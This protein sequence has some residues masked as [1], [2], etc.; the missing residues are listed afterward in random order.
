MIIVL[1]GPSSAGKT[2]VASTLLALCKKPLLHL[3]AD[4]FW[5]TLSSVHVYDDSLRARIVIALHDAIATL[6]RNG[7][8]VIVDGSLP[9]D[10]ALHYRCL[11][12][13]RSVPGT[14]V[15]GVT[16]SPEMLAQREATRSDRNAGWAERQ[17]GIVFEGVEL[18]AIVDTSHR[19]PDECVEELL[20][21][22]QL[23]S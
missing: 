3:E 11:E 15:I 4:R 10:R 23:E 13:L 6:G 7:L 2:S 9:T 5:P 21:A 14:L 8:D 22:L 20:R 12:I 19:S 16:C 17:S 18:D 1:T